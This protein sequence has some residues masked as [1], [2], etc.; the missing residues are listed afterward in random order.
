[1]SS[2]TERLAATVAHLSPLSFSASSSP[3]F[4][5]KNI[6]VFGAGL[7]G[8]GIAQ[9]SAQSGYKVVLCDIG[10]DLVEKG[11]DDIIKSWAK[12]AQRMFND[13]PLKQDQYVRDLRSRI[14]TTTD[15]EQAAEDADLVIEAV[16]ENLKIKQ[17]LLSTVDKA[18]K[19][20][21][22]LATNTS[23]LSV[24]DIGAMLSDERKKHFGGLH[25]FN[26]DTKMQL[27]EIIRTKDTSDAT[28]NAFID[29]GRNI[30]KTAVAC[31]DTPG[32]IVNRLLVPYLRDAILMLERGDASAEDIDTAM[33]L[34]AGYPMGPLELA[35]LVGLDTAK[36]I[37]D[38]WRERMEKT[39]DPTI[40]KEMLK[41]SELLDQLVSAKKL[42]R[43]TGEGF[44]K[45]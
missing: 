39:E 2:P 1:M 9:V 44:F 4:L 16:I 12:A 37:V 23:S 11:L 28:F 6:A 17:E 38:A 34:G 35:D 45:Y 7:M 10:Q 3:Q 13:N 14:K 29:Y 15:P 32:F 24:T 19:K 20:S 42:G 40:P 26:R 33:K 18:A 27:L 5:V 30:K 25:F 43:K 41:S 22:L 8:T 31:K 21:C 36:R